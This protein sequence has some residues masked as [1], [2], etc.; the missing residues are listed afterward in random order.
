MSG[1]WSHTNGLVA[2]LRWVGDAELRSSG[3][4]T[5]Q[6]VPELSVSDSR[7]EQCQN[8]RGTT[9]INDV[10]VSRATVRTGTLNAALIA[11]V[12]RDPDGRPWR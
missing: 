2:K 11:V 4:G 6:D 12:D 10:A 5:S 9:R 1:A 3:I 8:W 7:I